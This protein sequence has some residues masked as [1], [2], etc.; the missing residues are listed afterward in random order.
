MEDNNPGWTK[1]MYAGVLIMMPGIETLIGEL[2]DFYE[3]FPC[4]GFKFDFVTHGRNNRNF[5][6]NIEKSDRTL[7]YGMPTSGTF[8][9]IDSGLFSPYRSGSDRN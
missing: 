2:F 8:G 9:R 4:Y 6:G 5:F 1:W 7:A 3:N